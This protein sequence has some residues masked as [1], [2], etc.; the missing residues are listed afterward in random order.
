MH[1][2]KLHGP[3]T[4]ELIRVVLQAWLAAYCKCIDLA[5]KELSK[6]HIN[7]MED[8]WMDHYGIAVHLDDLTSDIDS[9]LGAALD[10]LDTWQ[11]TLRSRLLSSHACLI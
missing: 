8:V 2:D 6:G 9:Q 1:I 11:C 3:N 5:Y 4:P 10:W 7:D